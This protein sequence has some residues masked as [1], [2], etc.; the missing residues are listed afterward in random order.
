MPEPRRLHRYTYADYVAL[1][2]A[3]TGKYEFLDGEIYAIAGLSEEHSALAAELVRL[4]G[5][6]IGDRPCRVHTSD[7]RLYVESAGLA[8]FPDASVICG[9]LQQHKPS[10][11]ATALNPTILVEVTSDSSEDYDTGAKLEYYLT[12]PTLR[13]YVIV[14][15]R[16]RRI[17]VHARGTG[18]AWTTK[19]ATR[20]GR[21]EIVSLD[22]A[23]V[24][25]EI[26]RNSAV[27]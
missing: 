19:A 9:P 23:L 7:L 10:P 22:A 17:T 12:I 8:T 5:N 1:E 6:A 25:D 15:H 14:S 18:D 13:E 2:T 27:V 16:E 24:V 11:T 26:Y 21:V 4:L 3:S 20:G